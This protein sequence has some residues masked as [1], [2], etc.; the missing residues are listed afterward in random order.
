MIEFSGFV[1][2]IGGGGEFC[3]LGDY[4][5]GIILLIKCFFEFINIRYDF[6]DFVFLLFED[7]YLLNL[8]I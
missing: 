5:I 8:W 2:M 4:G 7:G 6:G 3:M 1:M